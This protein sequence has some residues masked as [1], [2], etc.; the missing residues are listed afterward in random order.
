MIRTCQ[1]VDNIHVSNKEDAV[2]LLNGMYDNTSLSKKEISEVVSLNGLSISDVVKVYN[3]FT[4][5]KEVYNEKLIP[6]AA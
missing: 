1:G 2:R 6:K 4:R 3:S 5:F